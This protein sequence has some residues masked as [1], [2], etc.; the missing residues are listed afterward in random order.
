MCKAPVFKVHGYIASKSESISLAGGAGTMAT[1]HNND[2][3]DDCAQRGI[4]GERILR[5]RRIFIKKTRRCDMLDKY[6][7]PACL[8]EKGHAAFNKALDA[9]NEGN[10]DEAERFYRIA[11][12]QDSPKALVNLGVLL[13]DGTDAQ[14]KESISLFLRAAEAGDTSGMRNLGCVNVI[15]VGIPVNKKEGIKWYTIAAEKGNV[16]AQCN[17]AVILR[18][19]KYTQRDY[20]EALKW[21]LMSAKAG[22]SRAQVN[23]AHMY[24]N[25]EGTEKDFSKAFHWYNEA[26]NN[27]SPRGM[28][29]LSMMYMKGDGI[30]A[31]AEKALELLKT[32]AEKGYPKA[33]YVI[34]EALLLEGKTNEAVDLFRSGALK[35][36]QR[37]I[38][39]LASLGSPKSGY[40]DMID[41][42]NKIE[43]GF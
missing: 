1:I 5:Y 42:N 27:G 29:N 13:I 6:I 33:I 23:L 31:D 26:A 8:D 25:G 16:K 36:D 7:D 30:P 35:G 34:G 15:G 41:R 43:Q 40:A 21:N 37:C 17:L 4:H 38:D 18:H 11:I 14:K 24:M 28:Y 12:D 3:D 22:Y 19:G 20:A 10:K 32:A 9:E 2:P 39:T